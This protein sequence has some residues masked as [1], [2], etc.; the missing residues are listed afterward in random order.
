MKTIEVEFWTKIRVRRTMQ[1]TEDAITVLN[2][3]SEPQIDEKGK[4]YVDEA[5]EVP[6]APQSELAKAF[7][8]ITNTKPIDDQIKEYDNYVE[9]IKWRVLSDE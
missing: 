3:I 7:E 4:K 8:V 5:Y 9:Q 6:E 1:V 2:A